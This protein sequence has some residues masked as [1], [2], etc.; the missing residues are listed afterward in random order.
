MKK[1]FFYTLFTL[2]ILSASYTSGSEDFT[3]PE[4]QELPPQTQASYLP[5]PELVTT[6]F[7]SENQKSE[8]TVKSENTELPHDVQP[9]KESA[10]PVKDIESEVQIIEEEEEEIEETVAETEIIPSRS[11]TIKRNQ[12]LDIEYPGAG[13]ICMGENTKEAKLAPFGSRKLNQEKTCFTF[14]GRYAGTT[15]L[16]FY[17]NDILTGSYI[18]DYLEVTVEAEE[19]NSKEHL[20]APS[21]EAVVPPPPNFSLLKENNRQNSAQSDEHEVP[22]DA[23]KYSDVSK[24]GSTLYNSTQKN[25]YSA[26]SE[27]SDDTDE[28]SFIYTEDSSGKKSGKT[29]IQTTEEE[30]AAKQSS[31]KQSL[32]GAAKAKTSKNE[33]KEESD[34]F[35]NLSADLILEKA[36]NAY[37]K[38]NYP[39]ALQLITDFFEKSDL[40]LDQ[41][42][43]L[44]G[45]ILEAK[46]P[47]QDIKSAI[48]AYE[49]IIKNYRQSPL[50][51]KAN[52]RSIYLKRFYINIR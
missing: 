41:A 3:E 16:H 7:P 47:V 48:D 37:E 15:L 30:L 19:T 31:A 33:I 13:W 17:K 10:S 42:L 6:E 24:S 26:Q 32:P 8:S 5:Q 23:V 18:D 20:M 25:D 11:V 21:Y 49:I 40:N 4:V 14:R 2:L 9:A 51:K 34:S 22:A 28:N 44:Q 50:W 39:E 36:R 43:Y 38:A 46:S 52:E 12:F 45:Q 29:I 35:E 27:N 1:I